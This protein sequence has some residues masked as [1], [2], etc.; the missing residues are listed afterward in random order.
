ML[1]RSIACK[2]GKYALFTALFEDVIDVILQGLRGGF[3]KRDGG[4]PT[5]SFR[6]GLNYLGGVGR[7][8][9]K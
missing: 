2:W 1:S 5:V 6:A 4:D 7:L 9:L 8:S 3:G